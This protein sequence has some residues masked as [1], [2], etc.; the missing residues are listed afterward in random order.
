MCKNCFQKLKTIPIS[1]LEK[2]RNELKN[3]NYSMTERSKILSSN[4]SKP[5]DDSQLSQIIYKSGATGN[6]NHQCGS[7]Q[8]SKNT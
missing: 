6:S 5:S 4:M 1:S 2:I 3:S 7:T 8:T